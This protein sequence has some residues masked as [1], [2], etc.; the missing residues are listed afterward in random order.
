MRESGFVRELML[1]CDETVTDIFIIPLFAQTLV[2][3]TKLINVL[4]ITKP[5]L[6]ILIIGYNLKNISVVMY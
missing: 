5:I 3:C 4:T 2:F 6:T 1:L